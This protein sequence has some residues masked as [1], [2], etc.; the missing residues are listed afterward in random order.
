MILKNHSE[1]EVQL[2]GDRINVVVKDF[3]KDYPEIEHIF[4]SAG[5]EILDKRLIT[6]SL[7]NIFI[8][9]VKK[10]TGGVEV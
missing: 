10:E 6:P 4:S 5:I 3:E 7:E 9:L 1:F 8:H 2:F